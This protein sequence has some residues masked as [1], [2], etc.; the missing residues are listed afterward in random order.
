METL[1]DACLGHVP[2][3]LLLSGKVVDVYRGSIING[4]VGI[5][6]GLIVY[7]GVKPKPSKEVLNLS[8]GFI[9]PTYI[10]GHIHIESSLMT[11]SA[12]ARAVIP[13]GTGCVIAD[14]HEIA[15][16]LGVDGIKFM[17]EDSKKTPLK[18]YFMIPSSVPSSSLETTGAVIGLK[19][20]EA[21]K[22]IENIL[23]LGEVMNYVGVINKDRSILDKLRACKRMIID[24]H[25][26]GLKEDNLCAY[27][28]AGINS[29][30]EVTDLEEAIEKLSLGVWIMI[31]EGST[32]KAIS[33]LRGVV[34]KGCPERV[35]LVTDDRHAVDIIHEG[36][37][38]YCLRR[39]VEEGLDP[40]DAIKMVTI[41]PAEYFGLRHLGGLSPGKSADIVVVDNLRD[42]RAKLV[43][44]DGKIVAK[45]GKWLC[46][47]EMEREDFTIGAVNIGE[48][49]IEDLCIRHPEIKY[50][51][52]V[53]RVIGL[54]EGQILTDELH[55]EMDV[56]DGLVNADPS[57]DILKI[58]VIERHKGSG[59]VG[60]GFVRGFGF[61]SGAI[62]STVAH[63][64]HNI[65][66]VGVKDH[67]IYRAV[68][69]LKEMNGG[70]VAVDNEKI[71]AELPLPIA[72]LMTNLSAEKISSR[73]EELNRVAAKMDCKI[74]N[75]FTVLSFL[76][77]PVVPKL[78]ITDH[79]LIDTEK[80]R[81]VSPFVKDEEL[82]V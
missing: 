10:D 32:A 78:K 17:I 43:I 22:S 49:K 13:R 3:D 23:G 64:S 39:A 74:K 80:Q 68:L 61:K 50:G 57:R 19:E 46:S 26:P 34:S 76:S 72:G 82:K 67:D 77:L 48:F 41:K 31:R 66:A 60:L 65:I 36:H 69:K 30:H 51:R 56:V 40:I 24:G 38:D 42:F 52:T 35:M 63:D 9:L 71:L 33:K 15:N 79:G 20:I 21:L 18:V 25:A 12:F 27:V 16:V 45:D 73:M 14:P 55:Y 59:R 7:F 28:L 11:P 54:R 53:V 8:S 37:L 75:P 58:C 44:I 5:K 4:Y 1:I 47:E 29:D 2:L 70:F 6:D 62:A 81:I